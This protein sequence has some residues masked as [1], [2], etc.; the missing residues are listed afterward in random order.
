LRLFMLQS[1]YRS[2]V[3]YSEGSLN[4][5]RSGL[6]R[7]YRTLQLL[8]EVQGKIAA[9][10]TPLVK[11]S[12]E[13]EENY[14]SQFKKLADKFDAAMDDDFNTAQALGHVFDMVRFTN[15]FIVD[16]KNMP[17]FNKARILAQAKKLFDHFGAVLGVFQNDADHFFLADKET[18]LHKRGLKIEE[19]ENLIKQRQ[20]AR[21]EKD[22]ARADAIRKELAGL[23]IVLKDSANST[24]W[25]IE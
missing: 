14:I 10:T 6:F 20:V 5:A 7:C 22:W 23:H 12:S 13:Q 2:P 3:D 16:E 21:Q 19:I 15:N 18:E 24:S 4:E 8:K 1:H 17:A 25:M 9:D 11:I